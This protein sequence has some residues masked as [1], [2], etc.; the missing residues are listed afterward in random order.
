MNKRTLRTSSALVLLTIL[1]VTAGNGEAVFQTTIVQIPI[2]VTNKSGEIIDD[3]NPEE[4]HIYQDGKELPLAS[5]GKE[6]A[7]TRYFIGIDTSGSFKTNLFDA[8]STSAFLIN[9]NG[10]EDQ[11]S[12]FR[13]ISSGQIETVQDF[14]SDKAALVNGLKTLNVVMGQTAVIDAIYVGVQEL[15][16]QGHNDLTRKGLVLISDGEDRNSHYSFYALSQL[17]RESNVPVFVIGMIQ[18]LD[19]ESGF[20]R[21]S[22]RHAA[23]KLLTDVAQQSGGLS[24]F[25]KN[26]DE[27]QK[28]A[29]EIAKSLRW[30]LVIGFEPTRRK[31]GFNKVEI[32]L[33]RAG[34]KL[35]LITKPGYWVEKQKPTEPKKAKS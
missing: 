3:L 4:V 9:Q 11:T 29:E 19:D 28:A 8:V 33:T 30:R 20:I 5:L 16:K 12:I 15:S 7:S 21:V 17:L 35:K 25:P 14:T 24:F 27:L 10:P 18:E 31:P 2:I 22:R 6:K 23:Q 34:E 26:K 13:F 32:K 1:L